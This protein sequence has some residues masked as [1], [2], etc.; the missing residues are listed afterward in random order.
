M[1]ELTRKHFTFNVALKKGVYLLE[2][3][4]KEDKG[5]QD[6]KI[7]VFDTPLVR[8]TDLQSQIRANST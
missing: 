4:K 3:V 8:Y 5:L 6:A 1:K 7:S 2:N